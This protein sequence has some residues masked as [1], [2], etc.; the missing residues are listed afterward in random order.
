MISK[1]LSPQGYNIMD[2]SNTNPFWGESGNTVLPEGGTTGQVLAKASDENYDVEWVDQTGGGGSSETVTVEVESTTTAPAGTE[3]FVSNSGTAQNVKLNFIIPRGEKGAKGDTGN[4]GATGATGPA[5]ALIVG[6]VTTG[7]A[8]SSADV[9]IEKVS[10]TDTY[11]IDFVIP[12]GDKGDKGDTGPQ[13]PQGPQGPAGSSGGVTPASQSGMI[14][15][16]DSNGEAEWVTPENALGNDFVMK[17][18]TQTMETDARLEF[19]SDPTQ[20]PSGDTD[21]T[22]I[23]AGTV[24]IVDID[25]NEEYKANTVLNARGM[26]VY[27]GEASSTYTAGYM[28]MA[29]ETTGGQQTTTS[30][31]MTGNGANVNGPVNFVDAPTTPTPTAN[32]QVANKAYVDGK[33]LPSVSGLSYNGYVIYDDF[34]DIYYTVMRSRDTASVSTISLPGATS[35]DTANNYSASIST[36]I[37][38]GT[39]G[40]RIGMGVIFSYAIKYNAGSVESEIYDGFTLN[41]ST[42]TWNTNNTVENR[43]LKKII[44]KNSDIEL[45]ASILIST[46]TTG[47]VYFNYKIPTG[48]NIPLNTPISVQLGLLLVG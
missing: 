40:L 21:E 10:G 14:L 29:N 4:T 19:K 5:P 33:A 27:E 18:G 41:S 26:I 32:T 23:E 31:T 12:K 44:I 1:K 47:R 13:G 20:D 25:S 9:D 48:S 22:S 38:G 39:N 2:P 37:K 15:V 45:W 8:G 16:S 17:S 30:V 42:A 34:N 6:S 7:A 11:K 24:T 28:S 36:Y 43:C 46:A 35:Y 3:A